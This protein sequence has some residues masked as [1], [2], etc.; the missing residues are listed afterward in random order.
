MQQAKVEKAPPD[1]NLIWLKEIER[2]FE[3]GLPMDNR[4]IMVSLRDQLP[5]GF[6]P[7]DLNSRLLYGTQPSIEGLKVLGDSSR[8]LPD[9]ESAIRYIRTRVIQ[10]PSLAKITAAEVAEALH[11]TTERAERVLYLIGM[12]VNFTTGASGSAH[13]YAQIGIDRDEVL[14]TYLAFTS[15]DDLFAKRSAPAELPVPHLAPA[16]RRPFDDEPERGGPGERAFIVMSMNASDPTLTDVCNTIKA[17]CAD[18]GVKA[19]RVDDIEHQDKITDKILTS[20]QETDLIIA[21]L[22]GER[23]N[24]YYEVGYA[25]AVGKRPILYRRKGTTLH[26]DLYVHNVP[27]YENMTELSAKLRKRLE[28]ILGRSPVGN[29]SSPDDV[30]S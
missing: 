3:Q 5:P 2:R 28:A 18:F 9:V 17:A 29:L 16:R 11:I 19:F 24:V 23:P 20:I 1:I 12:M 14:A 22:T 7:S 15:L 21:D 27:E 8:L 30:S 26:F 25:H 10:Y 4:E 6:K 13:G